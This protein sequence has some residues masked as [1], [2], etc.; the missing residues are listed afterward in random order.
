M[1]KACLPKAHVEFAREGGGVGGFSEILGVDGRADVDEALSGEV[2]QRLGQQRRAQREH[3]CGHA[4]LQQIAH[5]NQFVA[6]IQRIASEGLRSQA[7]RLRQLIEHQPDGL[8]DV[9]GAPIGHAG[10]LC[11]VAGHDQNRA[12][13]GTTA[14]F[15]VG[16]LVSNE[17]RTR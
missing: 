2:A 11:S 9:C 7:G 16:G 12:R 6:T 1:N 5:F 10:L 13:A 17:V 4:E 3:A 14:T 15:D 8:D